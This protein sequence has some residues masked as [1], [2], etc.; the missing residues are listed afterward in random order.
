MSAYAV[1]HLRNIAMGP[2]IVDYLERI[3]ATLAPYQG[4]FLIHG[5]RVEVLEGHWRGDLIVIEFPDKEQARSWYASEAYQRI[6]RLRTDNAD[7]DVILADGVSA[8]HR[9]TDVL[10]QVTAGRSAVAGQVTTGTARSGP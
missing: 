9:A 10:R 3:D 4:R 1:A 6:L 2:E 7:G 5:G 8:E